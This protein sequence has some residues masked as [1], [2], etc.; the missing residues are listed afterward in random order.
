MAPH[1]VRDAALIGALARRLNPADP[2]AQTN[3][4]WFAAR[5]GELE[6]AL[7]AARRA[8]AVPGAPGTAWHTLE[9]LA[10]GRTDGLL[11]VGAHGG[12]RSAA[13]TPG[14][15]LDAAVAA[16]RQGALAVAEVCYQAELAESPELGDAW[17]GLAVLH[18]QRGEHHAADA[19]WQRALVSPTLVAVHNRALAL[20]RRGQGHAAQQYLVDH[21]L[22]RSSS[23]QLLALAGYLALLNDQPRQALPWLER[24]V[25]I[26]PHLARAQFTLGLVCDRLQLHQQSLVATRRGLLLS[27][28]FMPQVWLLAISDGTVT[29]IP[30]AGDGDGAA[31]DDVLLALGRSLLETSHLGEALAVF[32]QVLRRLPSHPA[33]LFHR[34]VVLAKLRRYSEALDDWHQVQV[35]D[36]GGPLG[37]VSER[38]AESARRLADLF[39]AN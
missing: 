32:D 19:A 38:H 17:N 31:T 22:L 4:A 33:A 10:A 7:A 24:A 27:P 9:R 21:P 37:A 29:E 30:V 15:R 11:L 6:A 35:A 18:E 5:S 14:I 2:V 20:M 16:H 1:S 8:A 34:G 23:A 12:S 25:G 26:D 36:P 28:W 13:L 39:S 3:L